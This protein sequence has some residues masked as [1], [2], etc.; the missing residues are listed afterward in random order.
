MKFII[1]QLYGIETLNDSVNVH[2]I[3]IMKS[4]SRPVW[5]DEA[6]NKNKKYCILT[7]HV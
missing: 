3:G 7:N 4:T 1:E 5:Y 6:K 2:M